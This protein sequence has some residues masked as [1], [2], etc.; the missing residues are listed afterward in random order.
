MPDVSSGE[1]VYKSAH[2]IAISID[3]HQ[4]AFVYIFEY[5]YANQHDG[6]IINND[7]DDIWDFAVY[8][9]YY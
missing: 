9:S 3:A 6:T 5:A 1:T 7:D 4:F 8:T 2:T